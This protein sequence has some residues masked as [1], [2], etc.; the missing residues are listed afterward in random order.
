MLDFMKRQ[1]P[2]PEAVS[3]PVHILGTL[4]KSCSVL[5]CIEIVPD[6]FRERNSFLPAASPPDS[7]AWAASPLTAAQPQRPSDSFRS[8]IL[9][10]V[11]SFHIQ[12]VVLR[13]CGFQ[14]PHNWFPSPEKYSEIS[15]FPSAFLLQGSF[16]R[17]EG[18][19]LLQGRSSFPGPQTGLHVSEK[20]G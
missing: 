1:S 15:L 18:P 17:L 14:K 8:T 3:F 6:A 2:T 12:S 10:Y 20:G 5:C 19:F 9:M 11:V 16:P 4:C 7:N 13:F